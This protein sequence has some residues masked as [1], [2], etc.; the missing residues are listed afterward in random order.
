M[1]ASPEQIKA[2]VERLGLIEVRRREI[3][4]FDMS[5]TAA[6]DLC[7]ELELQLGEKRR[8]RG[9]RER[10]RKPIDELPADRQRFIRRLKE[11]PDDHQ[12]GTR[13]GYYTGRCRCEKCED[14]V[15]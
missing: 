15:S 1:R 13:Y 4:L 10:A 5:R 11:N 12:H 3:D 7:L 2:I 6:A 8:R 9:G 14:A